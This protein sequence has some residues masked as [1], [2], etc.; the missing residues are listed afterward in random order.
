M[1]SC[2]FV[3]LFFPKAADKTQNMDVS[4]TFNNSINL[5]I[6]CGEFLQKKKKRPICP[7][8]TATQTHGSERFMHIPILNYS[9]KMHSVSL[10]LCTTPL[11][12]V[13]QILALHF[14]NT[15]INTPPSITVSSGIQWSYEQLKSLMAAHDE[16]N[17]FASDPKAG[18]YPMIGSCC[19]FYPWGFPLLD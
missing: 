6:V 15:A 3:L 5:H 4:S 1:Q 14:Q 2:L 18:C 12:S 7:L 19:F 11:K 13:I 16:E 9:Q 10:M 17:I 8:D